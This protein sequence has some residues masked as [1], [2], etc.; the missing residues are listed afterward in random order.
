MAGFF[1]IHGSWHGGWC[2]DR[3]VPILES[4]GHTFW[5]PSLIGLG[6]RAGEVTPGTGLATHV[7]QITQFIQANNLKDLTLVGHSY[8]GLVMLGV[9]EHV[10][11]NLSHLVYLDAIIANH[12][13]SAF[14]LMPGMEAGVR[15]AMRMTGS[16]YLMPVMPPEE[17]GVT[18]KADID[19]VSKR[20][21][22]MPIMTHQEKV[23]APKRNAFKIP[24]TYIQC[25]QFGLGPSFAPEARKKGWR[26]L[27]A[28]T[29]HDIMITHP[30]LLADLLE[31][32]I[33]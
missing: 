5:A 2:W 22:P 18:A 26:I 29:G 16:T 10:P 21:S 31:Q 28:D 9:A 20:L 14:D 7:E 1:L 25:L 23:E 32:A 17:F 24:S 13:Q 15:Q 6:D 30:K 3:L 8:G 4:R 11:D 12:N 19:W 33:H 27:S